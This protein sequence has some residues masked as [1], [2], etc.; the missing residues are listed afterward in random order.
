MPMNEAP[1][2]P[3]DTK[4]QVSFSGWQYSVRTVMHWYQGG[5]CVLKTTEASGLDHSQ[6]LPYVSLPLA[7]FNLYPFPVITITMHTVGFSE[8]LWVF[9]W[10]TELEGDF[11][12]PLDLQLVSG[13]RT[14]LWRTVPS[15]LAVRLSLH[16]EHSEKEEERRTCWRNFNFPFVVTLHALGVFL[17][18]FRISNTIHQAQQKE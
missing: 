2:K 17:C 6:T 10:L 8:F 3:L 18:F 11:E 14:V 9:P 1:V 15:D 4:A 16:K 13:G 5:Q 7:D 12:N